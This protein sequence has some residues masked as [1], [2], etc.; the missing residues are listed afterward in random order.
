[1]VEVGGH[2]PFGH[3][4]TRLVANCY[5]SAEFFD[6]TGLLLSISH[7]IHG[8]AVHRLRHSGQRRGTFSLSR[9]IVGGRVIVPSD[10]FRIVDS[11]TPVRRDTSSNE[12]VGSSVSALTTFSYRKTLIALLLIMLV[13]E[14]LFK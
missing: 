4:A 10:I 6:R 9:T 14:S 2:V 13:T 1:M 12:A 3:A 5:R 8:Q 11:A 7:R